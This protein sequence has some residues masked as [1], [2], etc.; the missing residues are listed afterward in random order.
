MEAAEMLLADGIEVGVINARFVKP[1]DRELLVEAAR[2]YGTLV[3]VEDNVLAGGF[4]AAVVELL[5]DEGLSPRVVRLGIPDRFIEHAKP[6]EQHEEVGISPSAIAAR[7][8]A[9][10]APVA[11]VVQPQPATGTRG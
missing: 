11:E 7:V 10:V 1:L 3:T 9:L 5:A 2:E 8:R 4:G 6:E